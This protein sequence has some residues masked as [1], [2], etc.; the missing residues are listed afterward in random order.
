MR[1]W[2]QLACVQGLLFSLVIV[3]G[4]SNV[5]DDMSGKTWKAEL[6]SKQRIL[7]KK[8]PLSRVFVTRANTSHKQIPLS[9]VFVKRALNMRLV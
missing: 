4:L 5:L 6:K 8:I 2:E 9:W 1:N 7:H 3:L